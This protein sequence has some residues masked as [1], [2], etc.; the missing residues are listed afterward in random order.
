MR[1]LICLIICLPLCGQVKFTR[2][3]SSATANFPISALAV[4]PDGSVV[5]VGGTTAPDL[6]TT[7][8][9]LQPK[10][11]AETCISP[12]QF[13]PRRLTFACPDAFIIKLDPNG[14]IVFA[15][16]LG[17][18]GVD[19][20]SSVAIDN[21]GNIYVAGSTQQNYYVSVSQLID[22]PTTP[23]AK[24][25]SRIG[26]TFDGFVTK[27]D[28]GGKLI[29]STLVPAIGNP[30]IAVNTAGEV[31]LTAQSVPM[32]FSLATS[33]SYQPS[34]ATNFI[35]KINAAG[36]DF[37][38]ATYFGGL[39]SPPAIDAGGNV[40]FTGLDVINRDVGV[41]ALN[42]SGS[43][44][45]YSSHFGGT[46]TQYV[47]DV[48]SAIR[49][50]AQGDILVLGSARTDDFPFTREAFQDLAAVPGYKSF[51]AKLKPGGSEIVYAA[52]FEQVLAFDVDPAGN[53]YVAMVGS[54]GFQTTPG[55]TRRCM[56]GGASDLILAKLAPDGTLAD[57]SYLGGSGKDGTASFTPNLYS[58]DPG[59]LAIAAGRDGTVYIAGG[60]DSE[61]FPGA[62]GQT[63]N[64]LS[65]FITRL[66]IADPSK[67]D[68]PC[69]SLAVANSANLVEG[70]IAPG[71][72]VTLRGLGIGPD[73]GVAASDSIPFDLAGV[74]VLFDGVPGAI[75]YAQSKQVNV[76]APFEM[77]GPVSH[78]EVQYNGASSDVNPVRV[79]PV[80]PAI[81]QP[82]PSS[83]E[84]LAF[85]EDGS[86]NSLSNPAAK[87]S[88]VT[89]F[90]TG[91]GQF[92]GASTGGVNQGKAALGQDVQVGIG[93]FFPRENAEILYAGPASG[94]SSGVFQINFRI[95]TDLKSDITF[96]NVS[97]GGVVNVEPVYD[98]WIAIK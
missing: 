52:L 11:Y 98:I 25:T 8:G 28:P 7:T 53:A 81:F 75:L 71:E 85:N 22:F 24:Y 15:T 26:A 94:A 47:Y 86:I 41:T 16:Y 29:Y 62:Q 60:T 27:L 96:L 33:G 2:I 87:G 55:A 65:N 23:G 64:A 59:L 57:A 68:A 6:P 49:L 14:K 84:A 97:I 36:S 37:D 13:A 21:A 90:G 31:Y 56:A 9:A 70:A 45:A 34:F 88:I 54:Y 20:A 67:S 51:I 1:A 61:D 48:G 30:K 93:N 42:G 40:L 77:T 73:T 43:A 19:S 95:P 50:D 66:R 72:L 91:A 12:P 35:V 10:L 3:L 63:V 46:G 74:R 58:Q 89:L 17:G 76:Q 32:S 92:S 44:P 18:N 83:G 5:A 82:Y 38:Y 78:I 69:I 79:V 39:V 80:A 4:A